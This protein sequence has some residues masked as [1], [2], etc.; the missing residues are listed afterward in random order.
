MYI[1][2]RGD[3]VALVTITITSNDRVHFETLRP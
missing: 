3:Q 1:N 2:Y